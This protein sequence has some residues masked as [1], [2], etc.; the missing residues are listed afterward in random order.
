MGQ[1]IS[2]VAQDPSAKDGWVRAHP[3]VLPPDDTRSGMPEQGIIET[4]ESSLP[5][6]DYRLT[7]RWQALDGSTL[8]Q[9][10]AGGKA[11]DPG[12]AVIVERVLRWPGTGVISTKVI[13]P[14]NAAGPLRIV[15]ASGMTLTLRASDGGRYSLDATSGVLAAL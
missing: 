11:D 12:K 3:P 13:S 14:G 9:I 6:S 4:S 15:G 10:F 5:M 1:L 2:S 8:V 7:N